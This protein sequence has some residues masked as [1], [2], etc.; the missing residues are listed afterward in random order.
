MMPRKMPTSAPKSVSRL[1]LAEWSDVYPTSRSKRCCGS[2]AA[3]SASETPKKR[4]SKHCTPCKNAPWAAACDKGPTSQRCAG[5]RLTASPPAGSRLKASVP[6]PA[7]RAHAPSSPGC[8][9]PAAVREVAPGVEIRPEIEEIEEIRPVPARVWWM[10][11]PSA[12]TFGCSRKLVVPSVTAGA[13][14]AFRP[15]TKRTASSESIP[16]SMNAARF[17]PASHSR[18]WV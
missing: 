5:T 11:A 12:F 18:V 13:S 17:R 4:E 2:M 14:L 10:Y 16:R 7:H 1:W 15:R 3:T 8:A 9:P 6:A